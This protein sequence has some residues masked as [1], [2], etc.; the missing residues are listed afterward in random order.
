MS[1]PWLFFSL[2]YFDKL[3]LYAEMQWPYLWQITVIKKQDYQNEKRKTS[4][5]CH[6]SF[7][8]LWNEALSMINSAILYQMHLQQKVA[9]WMP[10][11][12]GKVCSHKYL[13]VR[14]NNINKSGVRSV[15]ASECNLEK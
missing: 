11:I 10:A 6:F 3:F 13:W 5:I 8:K 4:F 1:R 12:Y 7:A 14:L 2:A 15:K 9:R